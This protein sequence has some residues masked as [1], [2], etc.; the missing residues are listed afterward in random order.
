[1]GHAGYGIRDKNILA[2]ADVFTSSGEMR[3]E[4]EIEGGMRD[5]EQQITLS[6]ME[7]NQTSIYLD[8]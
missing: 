1:M 7:Q 2:R 5:E 6:Q 3:D 8:S 4:F